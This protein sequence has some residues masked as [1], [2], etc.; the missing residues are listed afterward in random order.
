MSRHLQAFGASLALP[1]VV[2]EQNAAT[3]L[4]ATCSE[5]E[6]LELEAQRTAREDI[7]ITQLENILELIE[8]TITRS[9]RLLVVQN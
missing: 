2:D 1:A 7:K 4:P 3:F 6:K 8:D 5:A 9:E